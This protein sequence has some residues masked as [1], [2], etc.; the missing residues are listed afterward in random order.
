MSRNDIHSHERLISLNIVL[1]RE[2][3]ADGMY[4]ATPHDMAGNRVPGLAYQA[5]NPH[6]AVKGAV[7]GMLR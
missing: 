6:A 2:P 1:T 3:N 5:K 4:T 7:R